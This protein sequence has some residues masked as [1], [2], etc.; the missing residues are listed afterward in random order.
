MRSYIGAV[1]G[2][3]KYYDIPISLRYVNLPP[4]QPIHKK[5]PWTIEEID[6]FMALMNKPL[7]KSAAA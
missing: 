3:A 5:H 6:D 1:Q 4:A 2:L 7:Y